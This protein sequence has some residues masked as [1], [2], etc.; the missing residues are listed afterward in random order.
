MSELMKLDANSL[1]SI[2]NLSF[3]IRM[4][5]N[6]ANATLGLRYEL[7]SNWRSR[8]WWR[9]DERDLQTF[10]TTL[11]QNIKICAKIKFES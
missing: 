4:F 2:N 11:L 3:L 8:N 10:D 9:I 7:I 1:F 5:F 6:S